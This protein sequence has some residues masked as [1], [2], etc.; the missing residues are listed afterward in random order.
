MVRLWVV[1]IFIG[2]KGGQSVGGVIALGFRG[3]WFIGV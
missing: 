2:D 1:Q 3:E